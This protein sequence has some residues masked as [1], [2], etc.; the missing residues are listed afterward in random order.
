MEGV[1]QDATLKDEEQTKEIK[2]SWKSWELGS[3]TKSLRYELKK[4]GD[5]IFSEE[6]NRAIYEMGTLVLIELR[7]TSEIC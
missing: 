3:G 7:P 6:S 5:I 1:S 2:K 4:K